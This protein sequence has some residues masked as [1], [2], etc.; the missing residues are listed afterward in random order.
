M[1]AEPP[2]EP[3]AGAMR[4][5]RPGAQTARGVSV[6]HETFPQHTFLMNGLIQGVKGL[7][8]FLSAPLI[9]ALSNVWGRKPFLISTVFFTCFPIPPMRIS[10][11]IW[12]YFR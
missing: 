6:L 5:K 4:E 9:I 8:S 10:P 2:P 3:A 12:C 11:W 1:S 7:L